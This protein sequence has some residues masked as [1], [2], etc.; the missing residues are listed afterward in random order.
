MLYE[1]PLRDLIARRMDYDAAL[2]T[3]VRHAA[4]DWNDFSVL[5]EDKCVCL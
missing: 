4:R 5:G 2:L 3:K 1:N